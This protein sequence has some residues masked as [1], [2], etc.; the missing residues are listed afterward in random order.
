MQLA[1]KLT[2]GVLLRPPSTLSTGFATLDAALPGGGWPQ[3]A[4]TELLP[5]GMGIG[6][7]SLLL[8]ALAQLTRSARQVAMLTP[9]CLPYAPALQQHG[10]ILRHL[11][12]I[13]TTDDGALLWSAEQLL[14]CSAV[15]AVLLWPRQIDDRR[16]RRL[17][18]AA[19]AGGSCALLYR[20]AAA[21]RQ[22][23]PAAL[24]MRLQ[25]AAD[26]LRITIFKARGGSTGVVAVHPAA[27]A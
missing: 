17:Q 9:P 22:S 2:S 11:L 5:A 27:A 13:H 25:P 1:R 12:L 6:E 23:S 3:G 7:L 24:R 16:V 4:V 18:L 19:E 8:P 20:E 14:R 15:G 26:G 10:L 21:H